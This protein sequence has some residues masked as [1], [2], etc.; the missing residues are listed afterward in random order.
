MQG[1]VTVFILA[2]AYS[3]LG[4][5][6]SVRTGKPKMEFDAVAVILTQVRALIEK[7]VK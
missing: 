3:V 1:A 5:V 6:H 4:N 7:V 2:E